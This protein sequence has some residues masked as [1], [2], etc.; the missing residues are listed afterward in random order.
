METARPATHPS[1]SPKVLSL[2]ESIPIDP[3]RE[4]DYLKW[5]TEELQRIGQLW[6][7]SP[8]IPLEAHEKHSRKWRTEW[9]RRFPSLFR[10]DPADYLRN[11]ALGDSELAVRAGFGRR[12]Q[13]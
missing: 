2:G 11:P 12:S 4:R 6:H 9:S 13:D 8:I 10:Y 1:G 3:E 7:E 5:L